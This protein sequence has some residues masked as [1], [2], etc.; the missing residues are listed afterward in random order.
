MLFC[1]K[2]K[3]L[4]VD[5]NENDTSKDIQKMYTS[6]AVEDNQH[7]D[8]S[9][10]SRP[11]SAEKRQSEVGGTGTEDE[12]TQTQNHFHISV[13]DLNNTMH[14]CEK[15]GCRLRAFGKC[16]WD[17]P[18]R[19]PRHKDGCGQYFCEFHGA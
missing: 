2:E 6:V 9:M 17:N 3:E 16:G 1:I 18:C 10:I 15:S 13:A 4:R 5:A 7:Q 19:I 8:A 11:G 14:Y 12:P